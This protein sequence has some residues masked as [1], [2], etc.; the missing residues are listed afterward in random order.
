MDLKNITTFF[1][2]GNLMLKVLCCMHELINLS[3]KFWMKTQSFFLL[4]SLRIKEIKKRSA[5]RMFF[6]SIVDPINNNFILSFFFL[7]SF[8]FVLFW[9]CNAIRPFLEITVH[10]RNILSCLDFFLKEQY[11]H[12]LNQGYERKWPSSSTYLYRDYTE[13]D[14]KKSLWGGE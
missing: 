9:Q 2:S 13:K 14:S 3:I 5:V 11:Q 10:K 7:M 1:Y 4:V 6:F 8:C 12:G